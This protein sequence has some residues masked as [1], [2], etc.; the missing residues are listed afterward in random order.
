MMIGVDYHPSFQAG[1]HERG[2][3]LQEETVQRTRANTVVQLISSSAN[4]QPIFRIVR[5]FG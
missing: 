2:L 1:G 5:P 4:A 3:S